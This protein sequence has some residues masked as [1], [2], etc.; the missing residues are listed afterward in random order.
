MIPGGI[1]YRLL[2][3]IARVRRRV[4]CTAYWG[5]AYYIIDYRSV[6]FDIIVC[7]MS[8]VLR[9]LS[10]VLSYLVLILLTD[11]EMNVYVLKN[12]Q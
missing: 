4:Y 8:W 11:H 1:D 6:T 12:I 7:C 2:F 10:R 9:N 5:V 3:K